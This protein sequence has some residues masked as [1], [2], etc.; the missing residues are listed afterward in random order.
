MNVAS[1]TQV[2]LPGIPYLAV[3]SLPLYE[4]NYSILYYDTLLAPLENL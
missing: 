3:L 2:Q 1:V 4:L